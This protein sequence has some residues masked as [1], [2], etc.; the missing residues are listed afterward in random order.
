MAKGTNPEQLADALAQELTLYHADVTER[1]NKLSEKAAKE[2]AK[3]TRATAPVGDRGAFKRSIT[4]GLKKTKRG[5]N[6]YAWYVKA[7]NYRLT[8]LL[9][10]GH[11]TRDGGRTRGNSFLA[12]A[13]AEVLPDYEQQVKEALKP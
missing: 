2:L 8:H 11:A 1:I 7:P 4:S 9:V 3:K 6:T 5:C 10:H 13:V 12:D